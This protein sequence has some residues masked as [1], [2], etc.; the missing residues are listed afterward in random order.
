[1]IENYSKQ[2]TENVL[3]EEIIELGNNWYEELDLGDNAETLSE[4]VEKMKITLGRMEQAGLRM[5]KNFSTLR[6]QITEMES[7]ATRQS[8]SKNSYDVASVYQTRLM[9]Y[10]IG[11]AFIRER[12]FAEFIYKKGMLI[13]SIDHWCGELEESEINACMILSEEIP[14]GLDSEL[15][16]NNKLYRLEEDK[17]I[18]LSD[19]YDIENMIY[20]GNIID[21]P[22]FPKP[23][24]STVDKRIQVERVHDKHPLVA[25]YVSVDHQ[26]HLLFHKTECGIVVY[27]P[28]SQG[29]NYLA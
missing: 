13:D 11:I 15:Q 10:G 6:E 2:N 8:W 22:L 18:V 24:F 14:F 17:S 19:V 4:E 23:D 7:K 1:M 5:T 25:Y 28:G 26:Y 12:D 9:D 21:T 20:P 27:L 3:Y 29:V 16:P